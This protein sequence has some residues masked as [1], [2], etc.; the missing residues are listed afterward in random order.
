[1]KDEYCPSC[2]KMPIAESPPK[3]DDSAAQFASQISLV[4]FGGDVQ[5]TEGVSSLPRLD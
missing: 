2:R 5:R 3:S 4:V 1:M